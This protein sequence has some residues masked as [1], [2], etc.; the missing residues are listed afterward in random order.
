MASVP[1]CHINNHNCPF[2]KRFFVAANAFHQSSSE[3]LAKGRCGH[4][5][6]NQQSFD[7]KC[8]LMFI[9]DLKNVQSFNGRK[10]NIVNATFSESSPTSVCYIINVWIKQPRMNAV[11]NETFLIRGPSKESADMRC[12]IINL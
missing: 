11:I 3:C 7:L 4:K 1:V 12:I 8:A 6:E 2:K 10:L 9:A 5:G